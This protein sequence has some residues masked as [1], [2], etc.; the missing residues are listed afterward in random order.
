MCERKTK[1]EKKI[2]RFHYFHKAKISA[3]IMFSHCQ[4]VKIYYRNQFLKIANK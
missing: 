3:L 4:A 2:P 1:K